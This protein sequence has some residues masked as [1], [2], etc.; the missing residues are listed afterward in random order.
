[1]ALFSEC[2]LRCARKVL[3]TADIVREAI[4]RQQPMAGPRFGRLRGSNLDRAALSQDN[5]GH[6]CGAFM[7]P[8]FVG[9]V[10]WVGL[11][12]LLL[13]LAFVVFRPLRRF[14]GFVFLTP[15]MG[16]GGALFGFLALGWFLDGRL[17]PEVATSVAFYLGFL[18]C[19]AIGSLLGAASGFLIWC[20][21]RPAR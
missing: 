8:I 19:G 14:A 9:L 18:L 17:R 20:R 11:V 16:V 1:M 5:L 2:S 3:D 21:T 7:L 12:A 4:L 6:R 13:G 10:V 15:T